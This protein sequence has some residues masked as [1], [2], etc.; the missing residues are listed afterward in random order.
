MTKEATMHSFWS[1]FGLTAY[2]ENS[3]PKGEE[4]P[5]FP[6]LTYQLV[7]DSF[8]NEVIMTASLWDNST[9][10]AYLTVKSNEI[11][12][13]IGRDGVFLPCDGGKVWIKKGV[14]F[15]QNMSDPD[16]TNIKRKLINITAEYLTEN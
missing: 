6:Y 9:S 7:V 10:W 5:E 11:A 12:Q 3:V 8:G 16:N 14:P 2:E 4:K 13:T 15:I 1:G